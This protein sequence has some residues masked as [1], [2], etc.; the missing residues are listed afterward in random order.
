[1]EVC[2]RPRDHQF[3]GGAILKRVPPRFPPVRK[4]AVDAFLRVTG[5]CESNGFL[6]GRGN[7][8]FGEKKH[9][10][11]RPCPQNTPGHPFLISRY[12][13]PLLVLFK[14]AVICVVFSSSFSPP[15]LP[16]YFY[17]ERSFLVVMTSFASALPIYQKLLVSIA[18]LV[19]LTIPPRV[20]SSVSDWE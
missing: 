11:D 20:E 1:M 5:L 3:E 18:C 2:T 17:F 14:S 4:D 16:F 9:Q 13:T 12:S 7:H 15:S 8:Y 6:G 19:F 10:T